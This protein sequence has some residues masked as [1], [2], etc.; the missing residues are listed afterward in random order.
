MV[1]P[2]M[3]RQEKTFPE[4]RDFPT[5]DKARRGRTSIDPRSF[6]QIIS[7]LEQECQRASRLCIPCPDLGSKRPTHK[8]CQLRPRLKGHSGIGLN[9]TGPRNRGPRNRGPR[10]K[11][12]R[13]K[14]PRRRISF[15][16][17]LQAI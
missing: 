6:A 13:N 8:L 12:P 15:Q 11:G 1:D 9:N 17:A 14:G 16:G 7:K 2:E 5:P 4:S 3:L 10:N